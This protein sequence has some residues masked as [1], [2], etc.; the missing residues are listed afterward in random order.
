MRI[1]SLLPSATEIVCA[2]GGRDDLVGRSE[3]CDFPST[4]AELPIVMHARTWDSEAPS[5]TID[6]RVRATRGVGE[7][8]YELDVAALARLRPD[9]LLTQDLCSVCSV[10]EDEV[11]AACREAGVRPEI[12]SI[13]PHDVEDVWGSI[14]RIGTAVGREE[15]ARALADQL[16]RRASAAPASG[17]RP[18]VAVIEWLDPPILAGLWTPGLIE[19]AGGRSWSVRPGAPGERRDWSDVARA[20]PDLVVVSPCSFSVARTTRE[21][22]VSPVRPMVERLR[23]PLGLWVADEAYFSRPGP[24]LADGVELLRELLSGASPT[25]PMPVQPWPEARR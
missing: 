9:V 24:R 2:L 25:A 15:R 13:T 20:S 16:R 10:T 23:P 5:A 3:E 8:L 6:A 14:E 7:S 21:L 18:L 4:V 1:V 11:A 22:E 19:R 12:V 17:A